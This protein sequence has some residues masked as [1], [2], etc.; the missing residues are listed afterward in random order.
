MVDDGRDLVGSGAEAFT[1]PPI[2]QYTV[3]ATRFSEAVRGLNTVAVSM[4]DA[5]AKTLDFYLK[6]RN[7]ALLSSAI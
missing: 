4:D 3:Q 7:P 5:I 1:F 6:D 2:N